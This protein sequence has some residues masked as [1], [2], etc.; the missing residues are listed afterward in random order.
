MQIPETHYARVG[1]LRLAYQKWGEGPPLMIVPALV[2]NVEVSWEHELYRRAREHLG[3]YMTCVEFDKRGIGLSDRFD[4]TPTLEERI[5]D[6]H[7]VMDV[8]AWDRANFLGLSEGGLM[9]QLFAAD[10][11]E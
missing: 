4:G 3:K 7:A 9:A 8:V 11:P 10:F 1:D 5:Q 2:S 6:I